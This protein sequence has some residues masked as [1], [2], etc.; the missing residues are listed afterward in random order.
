MVKGDSQLMD[1][2]F[3]EEGTGRKKPHYWGCA[4]E[5]GIGA[6][7]PLSFGFSSAVR[8]TDPL[9]PCTRPQRSTADGLNIDTMIQIDLCSLYFYFNRYFITVIEILLIHYPWYNPIFFFIL[10]MVAFSIKHIFIHGDSLVLKNCLLNNAKLYIYISLC[11][12]MILWY[13]G[14]SLN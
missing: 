1:G 9:P 13:G 10:N 11:Y 7:V 12:R 5:G 2:T 3:S 8:L 6:A 14:K 4:L